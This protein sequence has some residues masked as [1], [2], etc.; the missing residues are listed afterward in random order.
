MRVFILMDD[1]KD[2]LFNN[3]IEH[4]NSIE[5]AITLFNAYKHLDNMLY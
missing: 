2:I 5:S 4:S 1:T 3:I